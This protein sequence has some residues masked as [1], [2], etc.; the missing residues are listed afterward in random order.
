MLDSSGAFSAKDL[1]AFSDIN[2][3]SVTDTL[4]TL[5]NN[6]QAAIMHLLEQDTDY[7]WQTLFVPLEEIEDKLHRYWS[8]VSHLH[9]VIDSHELREQYNNCLPKLSDYGTWVSQNQALYNAVKSVADSPEYSRL[10]FPERKVIDNALR[11]F[12]LAGVHLPKA[13]KEQL[14]EIDK[15]LS[16][17][18]SQFEQNLL[19]VTQAFTLHFTEESELAG[20]PAS[21]M[22]GAKAAAES[23]NLAGWVITLE[24]PA[25]IAVM[26]YADNR[27]LR[28]NLYT[29]YMTR[30]SD[31][32]PLAGQW[33]NTHIIEKI[34]TLRQ[35]KARLL[36]FA[37]YPTYS[38]TPKMAKSP[39]E[40]L[41]F[42]HELAQ[43][44]VNKGK[45][46]FAELCAFAQ[47]EFGVSELE[48]WDIGYYSEKLRV[49]RYNISQEE[50]RPY[51]PVDRV[52]SGLFGV[53][54]RLYGIHISEIKDADTW[55]NDVQAFL[56]TDADNK[57]RG[58]FY[59][60]LYARQNKRGGAWM[61]D[62]QGR[63]LLR[64]GRVQLPIAFLTCNLNPPVGDTPALFSHD[65]VITLFHEFGHGLHHMLTQINAADV[66]GISGVPWDAVELPS[67]F[68]E[69]WCWEKEALDLFAEHYQTHEKLPEALFEKLT[70]A[71]NFQSA[72]QMARQVE[73]S[74]FD[75]RLH[76]EFNADESNMTQ[77]ILDEVRKEVAVVPI[78]PFN[79][80]QNG[81]S[82]IFAGGY[83]AGYYSYK[84]AEVL[85]AD[86]FSKFEEDGIFNATTGQ[87]FLGNILEQ[88]G[89][90]DPMD[91]FVAFRGR[92]P[93][94][95]ALLRHNGIKE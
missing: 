95:D 48:P 20:L 89:A 58:A 45:K 22:A 64:D 67:Q 33:D 56:I 6:S 39:D 2:V 38:L 84:W 61:D 70:A 41:A 57:P 59:I 74:L 27:A 28:Q 18:C 46:E 68:M 76:L 47:N 36:G 13:E 55:H 69:N 16:L 29:A 83:A 25:Y 9:H 14:A 88:G 30:A 19:D 5:L 43:T 50:L 4:E 91:C 42:L 73:F 40:V 17:I 23:S 85:S 53:V 87:S 7:S 49:S 51:F 44:S 12:R 3:A 90:K 79:R 92:K 71:R 72:M 24:M 52:L 34:L 93:T 63:R 65:E 11:D 62:C 8:R 1:P 37:N 32:G 60:D 86:A 35:Q 54:N 82:H 77:R 26:T 10:N 78:A 66:A 75:F 81:F 31:Q 21:A 80:F 94:I 15:E